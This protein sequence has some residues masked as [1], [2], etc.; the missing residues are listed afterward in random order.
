MEKYKREYR[1]YIKGLI[2]LFKNNKRFIL[3]MVYVPLIMSNI[4]LKGVL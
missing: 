1:N 4:D 3:K 2:V